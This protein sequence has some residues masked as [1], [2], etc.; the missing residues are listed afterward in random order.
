MSCK[1]L[2]FEYA[3]TYAGENVS[4]VSTA[5]NLYTSVFSEDTND[6][7]MGSVDTVCISH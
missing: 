6:L 5:V 7:R 4:S 3:Q 2:L 1:N